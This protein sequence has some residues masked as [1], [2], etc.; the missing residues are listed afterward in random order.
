MV[1]LRRF[2]FPAFGHQ[3]VGVTAFSCEEAFALARAAAERLGWP[4]SGEA[5]ADI[6]VREL[7]PGHVL[8]NM[9]PPSNPGVWYP[10]SGA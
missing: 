7:D 8:P 10:W 9:G 4:L 5:V 6:D 3:G 2:W 1:Q